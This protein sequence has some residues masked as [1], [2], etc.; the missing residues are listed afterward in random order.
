[1]KQ[2]LLF[3]FI[4]LFNQ[5]SIGDEKTV[6]SGEFEYMLGSWERSND[7]QGQSTFEIWAK[8]HANSYSG[9]GFTLQN[10]DTVFKEE[11]QIIKRAG[12]WQLEVSGV[13]EGITS[14]LISS[15]DSSSFSSNNIKN[16]FPKM[17]EYSI[18]NNLLKARVS[19]NTREILF[20]FEKRKP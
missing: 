19:D 5:C 16:E 4:I 18:E 7:G 17:I 9:L 3:A 10:G 14:F 2:L 1:M 20:T 11:M 12:N 8:D 13:N 15:H 6:T